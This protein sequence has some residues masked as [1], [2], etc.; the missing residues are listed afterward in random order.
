MGAYFASK[1]IP[2]QIR[3][4]GWDVNIFAGPA[5]ITLI[6]LVVETIFLLI[7]LPETRHVNEP[8][9]HTVIASKPQ[10]SRSQGANIEKRIAVLRSL[11][12]LHFLFLSVF[13][14]FEFTL[15]FLTFDR[16]SS[17]HLRSP[18]ML[19]VPQSLIGITR[20]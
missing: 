8:A 19:I 1:P 7:F 3:L 14:G 5:F 12:R 20:R 11:R 6:L 9:Q 18:T 15:T 10:T 17:R 2:T 16:A 4:W 13:S